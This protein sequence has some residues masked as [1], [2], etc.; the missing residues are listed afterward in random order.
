VNKSLIAEADYVLFQLKVLCLEL[1]VAFRE[2]G[3]GRPQLLV[4]FGLM[5]EVDP[6]VVQLARKIIDLLLLRTVIMLKGIWLVGWRGEGRCQG[7]SL[8]G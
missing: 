4:L 7:S 2:S 6:Q 8:G 3:D 5:V 1:A